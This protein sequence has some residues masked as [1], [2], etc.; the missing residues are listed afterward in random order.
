MFLFDIERLKEKIIENE[1]D[2]ER[3]DF[4]EDNENAHKVLQENKK[5]CETVEK[6]EQLQKNLED[7]EVLIE[8]GLEEDDSEDIEKE[9][10]SYTHLTLPT[11][12]S[13]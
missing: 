8:L 3:Q 1:Q 9:A 12:C 4:W 6:F 11:I 7:I 2:M 10:V 5:L 13:V